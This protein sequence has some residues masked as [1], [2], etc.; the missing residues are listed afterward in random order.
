M[1]KY[2]YDMKVMEKRTAKMKAM[3]RDDLDYDELSSEEFDDEDS[4][5]FA[6]FLKK[7]REDLFSK[8]EDEPYKVADDELE[9]SDR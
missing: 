8:Y 2:R 1:L 6:S 9:H 3:D 7:K 5:K 4:K